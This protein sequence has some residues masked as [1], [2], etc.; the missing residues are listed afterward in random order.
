MV[1]DPV[2]LA[3]GTFPVLWSLTTGAAHPAINIATPAER[4]ALPRRRNRGEFRIGSSLLIR[5]NLVTRVGKSQ[6]RPR[7]TI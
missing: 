3:G 2:R 6:R 5:E 7:A 1:H 4:T